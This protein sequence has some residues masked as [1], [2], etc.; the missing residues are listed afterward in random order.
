M[1][2]R[3]VGEE[4]VMCCGIDQLPSPNVY[5]GTNEQ[6]E[7]LATALPNTR[8]SSANHQRAQHLFQSSEHFGY[9]VMFKAAFQFANKLVEDNKLL[10]RAHIQSLQ[11][12][13]THPNH[14]MALSVNSEEEPFYVSIHIR[15]STPIDQ[16]KTLL[17][18]DDYAY[19]CF[20]HTV[21]S[22]RD[23]MR[24]R[25][26][27]ILLA[28]D[29][30][31]TLHYWRQREV[32]TNCTV[33]VSDHSDQHRQFSEHGPFTGEIAVRDLEL[34]SRGDVFI[35]STYQLHGYRMWASSFS[36]LIA[37]LRAMNGRQ[38]TLDI[39]PRFIP[40]CRDILG[41]RRLPKPIFTDQTI[42]CRRSKLPGVFLPPGC[43]VKIDNEH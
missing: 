12:N 18:Q 11:R 32:S 1:G 19:Q 10:L 7:F 37:E 34:L 22:Y 29:R 16:A 30:N 38:Y 20:E 42:D 8:L 13:S 39:P 17:E 25:L 43:P 24:D 28:T 4:I 2:H 41:G 36:M 9:G 40:E 23:L 3:P 21:Y 35:G 31:E 33:V 5:F 27:V 15:H 6:H 14:A 26:C